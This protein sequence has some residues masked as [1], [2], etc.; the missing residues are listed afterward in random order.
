MDTT[1]R[2]PRRQPRRP[3]G[4]PHDP[5]VV[6]RAPPSI[7]EIVRAEAERRN[8]TYSEIAREA[9]EAYV[10][11]LSNGREYDQASRE[12]RAT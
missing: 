12:K 4:T 5:F 3:R 2:K 6:C 8:V 7:V 1:K 9:L 10:C 11:A